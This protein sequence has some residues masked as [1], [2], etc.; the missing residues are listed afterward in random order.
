MAVV[1][2]ENSVTLELRP[3]IEKKLGRFQIDVNP[4]VGRAL[5]GPAQTKDGTSNR[6]C[7][8]PTR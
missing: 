3:I 4:V 7:A 2:E 1:Y 8:S 6:V 5:R